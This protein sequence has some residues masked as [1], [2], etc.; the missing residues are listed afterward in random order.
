[1]CFDDLQYYAK[2]Y[3]RQSGVWKIVALSL[4]VV[5]GF[6]SILLFF[7]K[8]QKKLYIKKVTEESKDIPNTPEQEEELRIIRER[9]CAS[10]NAPKNRM[11]TEERLKNER[12]EEEA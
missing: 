10:A 12:T 4:F 2:K 9:E 1:M 7:L 6:M 5:I 8:L 11:T 3:K